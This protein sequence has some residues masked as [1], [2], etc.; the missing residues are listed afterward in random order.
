MILVCKNHDINAIVF[1]A[2]KFTQEMAVVYE[3]ARWNLPKMSEISL[4]MCMN[5][6]DRMCL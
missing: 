4:R 2:A 1:I 6:L 3:T 5:P